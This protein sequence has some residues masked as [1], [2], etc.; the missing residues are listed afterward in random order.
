MR[1]GDE[2][3]VV[4]SGRERR[5]GLR[6][7]EADRRTV[8]ITG[9][10]CAG[11]GAAAADIDDGV[12][13]AIGHPEAPLARRRGVEGVDLIGAVRIQ[14][15][16]RAH[17]IGEADGGAVI[18]AGAR[19]DAGSGAGASAIHRAA[20][21]ITDA[22]EVDAV[23]VAV[24][25]VVD[26]IVADLRRC[27]P[28]ANGQNGAFSIGT[29][30]GAIEVVVDVVIANLRRALATIGDAVGIH[31]EVVIETGADIASVADAVEIAVVAWAA[32]KGAVEG[33][34]V[35]GETVAVVA[36]LSGLDCTV[37]TDGRTAGVHSGVDSGV[38]GC[39][40]G[41]GVGC[42]VGVGIRRGISGIGVGIGCRVWCGIADGVTAACVLRRAAGISG[43]GPEDVGTPG[44]GFRC[45]TARAGCDSEQQERGA[46]KVSGAA[47]QSHAGIPGWDSFR[48]RQL[49][50]LLATE[51][52]QR[53]VA[54]PPHSHLT[55][56]RRRI[57]L[58]CNRGETSGS[59]EEVEQP[60]RARFK[61]A[62][63]EPQRTLIREAG[64]MIADEPELFV[65]L[66]VV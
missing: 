16:T 11:V 33:A 47:G 10:L 43:V 27:A 58:C 49:P 63:V 28:G 15:T 59:P 57:G 38:G 45:V 22:V 24:Q 6:Q 14:C 36:G 53:Q 64:D 60:L 25:V 12:E 48:C 2:D 42:S 50:G 51:L 62:A 40:T 13:V 44:I 65:A 56:V 29:I 41:V 66:V 34:A 5:L 17:S 32:L 7:Q 20:G 52:I 18:D 37:A 19:D 9:D 54:A 4:G 39:V 35:A 61:Q 55:S 23:G 31:V 3:V 30:D 1:A 26:A 21:R 8:V 46:K